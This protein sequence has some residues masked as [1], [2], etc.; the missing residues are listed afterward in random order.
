[1]VR[2][3]GF[4]ENSLF[5]GGP[6]GTLCDTNSFGD[7]VVVYD[8]LHDRWILTN[9][10]FTL[11]GSSPVSPYYE[12]IAAS[13]TG[14]PVA[15]SWWLYAG[16]RDLGGTGMPPVGPLPDCPKFGIWND[17]CL[18]MGANGYSGPFNGAVFAS[19]NTDDLYNGR[20]LRSGLG[21]IANTAF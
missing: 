20:A 14:D 7:P 11:S 12:C 10:A 19:F 8:Q 13:K 21:R 9:L 3:A 15:G 2:L 17:G 4:T 18:Y 1:G 5:S 6:T 16:G